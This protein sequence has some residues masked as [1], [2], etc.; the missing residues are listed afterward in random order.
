MKENKN[1]E[2]SN[3]VL[4]QLCT[5]KRTQQFMLKS[6]FVCCLFLVFACVHE[7]KQQSYCEPAQQASV[8]SGDKSVL[9]GDITVALSDCSLCTVQ[10]IHKHRKIL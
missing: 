3:H 6:L 5:K 1:T 10:Y 9:T 2:L 8:L 4:K 7:S